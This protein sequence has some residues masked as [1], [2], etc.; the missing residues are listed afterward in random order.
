M[1]DSRRNSVRDTW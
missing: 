1:F